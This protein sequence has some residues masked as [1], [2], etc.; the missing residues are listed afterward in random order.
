MDETDLPS[1]LAWKQW[2]VDHFVGRTCAR[3]NGEILF[4][5]EVV[6]DKQD[7]ESSLGDVVKVCVVTYSSC[8]GL[9][10]SISKAMGLRAWVT[11]SISF[12]GLGD[13][14]SSRTVYQ[15]YSPELSL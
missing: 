15:M 4:A 7:F 12:S 1:G 2:Q 8:M 9:V 10:M 5:Q 6:S 13:S 14:V 3:E 11:S